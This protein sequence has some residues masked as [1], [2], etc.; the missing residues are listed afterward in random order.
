M[1]FRNKSSLQIPSKLWNKLAKRMGLGKNLPQTNGERAFLYTTPDFH[2]P[3]RTLYVTVHKEQYFPKN[4]EIVTTGEYG[5]GNIDLFPCLKC[6][7]GFLTAIFLHELCHAW[8][9]QYHPVFSEKMYQHEEEIADN[10]MAQA[11]KILSNEDYHDEKNCFDYSFTQKTG[12]NQLDTF[13]NFFRDW[14]RE[15]EKTH[16]H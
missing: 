12:L 1:K 16:T 14:I 8:I 15:F 7:Y 6:T 9:E 10:F 2:H 4:N 13:D 3:I 5:F 11:Y